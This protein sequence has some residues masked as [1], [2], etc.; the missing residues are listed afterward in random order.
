MYESPFS[1]RTDSLYYTHKKTFDLIFQ[2]SKNEDGAPGEIRTPDPLVRSQMLYPAEL[3][4][5]EKHHKPFRRNVIELTIRV[6][7]LDI[8]AR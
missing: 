1:A 8:L 5:R 6:T 3:R 7:R 2:I 4:A